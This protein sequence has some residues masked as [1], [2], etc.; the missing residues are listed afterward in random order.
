MSSQL[1]SKLIHDP[2]S[3]NDQG[4]LLLDDL[5]QQYPYCQSGQLLLAC[6]YYLNGNSQYPD[7]LK[8]ASAYAGDRTVLKELVARAKKA[9]EHPT[10]VPQP[11]NDP[12]DPGYR[13]LYHP[14]EVIIAKH[15]PVKYERMTQEELLAIVK[16]RLSEINAEK[17]QEQRIAEIQTTASDSTYHENTPEPPAP[18]LESES[19]ASK[20]S[21]I[22]KFI[23]EE[24]RISKPK[25]VF[26]S[27]TDSAIRSN[28]DEEEIV[29]ETL[30]NLYAQQGN[31]QKAI[32]I[33]Q[34]LSLINQE[35]SR[36]FATQ[37][38]KLSS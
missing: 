13:S 9:T 10:V 5:V 19:S 30:A 21:L 3:V 15:S 22:D 36:Y 26:F 38:E 8:K 14:P 1:F 6:Y 2:C 29:S 27:A 34:K 12:P 24:P 16:K 35:K 11:V 25:A 32:H 4:L 20:E 33:Y 28:F 18:F 31:I 17:K 37:I 7:Q 23:R